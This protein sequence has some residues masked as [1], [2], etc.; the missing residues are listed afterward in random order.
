M[1]SRPGFLST[2]SL[3]VPLKSH[4][5]IAQS[6]CPSTDISTYHIAGKFG[7]DFNLAVWRIGKNR[8]IKLLHK[9]Y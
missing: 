7:E 6:C 1:L 2:Y 8:Q 5:R 4:I 3:G 9:L